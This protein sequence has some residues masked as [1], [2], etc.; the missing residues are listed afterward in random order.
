[1]QSSEF[2]GWSGVTFCF[3]AGGR[4]DVQCSTH[5]QRTQTRTY[6]YTVYRHIE[7]TLTHTSGQVLL[8]LHHRR[9]SSWLARSHRFWMSMQ[10][11]NEPEQKAEE[12]EVHTP[13]T[14]THTHRDEENPGQHAS[15]ILSTTDPNAS[16]SSSVNSRAHLTLLALLSQKLLCNNV[17]ARRSWLFVKNIKKTWQITGCTPLAYTALSTFGCKCHGEGLSHFHCH[18]S[19]RI[20]SFVCTNL[21]WAKT[22]RSRT[23]QKQSGSH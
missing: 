2:N 15:H 23:L 10:G 9:M 4:K 14:H 1:M 21:L 17:K 22:S 20:F 18:C 8:M 19:E 3:V 6:I 13:A 16:S 5:T 11:T 12:W 7:N